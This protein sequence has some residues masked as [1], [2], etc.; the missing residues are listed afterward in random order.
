MEEEKVEDQGYIG[1][2]HRSIVTRSE[3]HFSLYKPG[4]GGVMG[5]EQEGRGEGGEDGE[6]AGSWMRDHT[7]KFHQGVFS[8][9]KTVDYEFIVLHQHTKV[10]R[11]QLEETILLDHNLSI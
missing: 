6:K 11:R 3:T 4:S 10:I 5:G 2:S 9:Q 1:E 8:K 7:L